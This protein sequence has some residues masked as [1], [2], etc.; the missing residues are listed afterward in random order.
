M[1]NRIQVTP[2][3][4]F[5]PVVQRFREGREPDLVFG[6]KNREPSSGVGCKIQEFLDIARTLSYGESLTLNQE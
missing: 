2:E 3:P 6:P 5:L 4:V 1:Q